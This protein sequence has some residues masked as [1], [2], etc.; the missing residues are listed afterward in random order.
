MI[1]ES[2]KL[3]A[4]I[5]IKE[6]SK[7]KSKFTIGPFQPGLGTTI[8]NGLRRF[9]YSFTEGYAISCIRFEPQQPH[10]FAAIPGVTEDIQEIIL[11]L[12]KIALKKVKEEPEEKITITLNKQ[13]AF[14]ASDIT[15][16]SS[17][18]EV[19]NDPDY[20]ICHMDATAKFDIE[21][22][23]S[24]GRGYQLA[25]EHKPEKQV[26]GSFPMDAIY[27]PIINVKLN[28]ENTLVGKNPDY[29]KIILEIETNGA[30][31]GQEA[32]KN[33]AT[34]LSAIF[35][36]IS[37]QK[38]TGETK[39]KTQINTQEQERLRIRALLA[40]PLSELPLSQRVINS[41]LANGIETL[42]NIVD[43]KVSDLLALPNF[44]KKCLED[45]EKFL[46]SQNLS[47]VNHT[48]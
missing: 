19:M 32:L 24:K 47:L 39:N 15:K 18:F 6:V 35:D 13:T 45:L 17:T 26:F 1:N 29:E 44:G 28:I 34:M 10:E 40:T 36:R 3:L 42:K 33:A 8:G 21:L 2:F 23:I 30:I 43:K 7:S 12:K 22:T 11:N 4:K 48:P 38:I 16:A 14:K 37:S 25:E 31:D 41:L 46:Q 9:L 27:S 5:N 20:V